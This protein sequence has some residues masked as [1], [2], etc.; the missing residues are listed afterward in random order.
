MAGIRP[1][2]PYKR[3]EAASSLN[4]DR[5]ELVPIIPAQRPLRWTRSL[6]IRTSPSQLSEVNRDLQET[7]PVTQE[8]IEAD[9]NEL[10]I[11]PQCGDL[12]IRPTQSEHSSVASSQPSATRAEITPT[13]VSEDD[14]P[15]DD[16]GFR[17]SFRSRRKSEAPNH[18]PSGTRPSHREQ[19]EYT[20][21]I[22]KLAA[23]LD[24]L[25]N[26]RKYSRH[27]SYCAYSFFEGSRTE[28]NEYFRDQ[29]P[30]HWTWQ[31]MAMSADSIFTLQPEDTVR[32]I[33]VQDP[34]ASA[35]RGL[36][37]YLQLNPEFFEQHLNRS[38][39]HSA[40]YQDPLPQT[41]NTNSA[42][43][44]HFSLRWFRP[45]LRNKEYPPNLSNRT[46]LLRRDGIKWEE[47]T[48]AKR[49]GRAGQKIIT[50]HQVRCKTNIL[51]QEWNLSA[52]PE[53]QDTTSEKF[54]PCSWEERATV[55]RTSAAGNRK[56]GTPKTA[57]SST[58][59]VLYIE[60][61]IYRRS[62]VARPVTKFHL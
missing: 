40:S 44:D 51:R 7:P 10:Q 30:I 29:A 34:G 18:W 26:V 16:G 15:Q 32:M 31:E 11:R 38:G 8:A 60:T 22:V 52:D 9:T 56:L 17:A 20:R 54:V 33:F 55:Y 35:I 37:F 23:H 62:L 43:K 21:V 39:F 47:T 2:S 1:T 42:E 49:K 36:G 28:M 45:V 25:I 41:W 19:R 3:Q 5:S 12:S 14:D 6:E 53:G 13:S 4:L 46:E 27:S 57:L 58:S 24:H 50:H 59:S 48:F 61:L